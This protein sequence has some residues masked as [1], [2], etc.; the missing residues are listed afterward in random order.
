MATWT[1]LS[2]ITSNFCPNDDS[3]KRK[4]AT[5][6]SHPSM[7]VAHKNNNVP[8]MPVPNRADTQ[9]PRRGQADGGADDGQVIR[10]Q[11]CMAHQPPTDAQ[12]DAAIDPMREGAV[13]DGAVRPHARAQRRFRGGHGGSVGD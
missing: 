7:M 10:P 4:R 12:R 8:A 5:S 2:V 1:R 11:G 13:T 3:R 6:P 9:T